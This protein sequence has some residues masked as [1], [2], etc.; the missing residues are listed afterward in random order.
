MSG[1]AVVVFWVQ[2]TFQA[3]ELGL[4]LASTREASLSSTPRHRFTALL[5]RHPHPCVKAPPRS[6]AP[7]SLA[8][9]FLIP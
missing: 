7:R 1:A 5:P 9:W 4:T 8:P 2:V 6:L 3:G